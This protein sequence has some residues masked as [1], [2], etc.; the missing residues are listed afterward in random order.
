MEL[1]SIFIRFS[2]IFIF[3]FKLKDLRILIS[4][5][6]TS[7]N[8]DD[9]RTITNHSSGKMGISIANEAFAQGAQVTLSKGKTEVLPHKGIKIVEANNH[10]EMEQSVL[11]E[12]SRHD[13]F[14]SVAAVSDYKA[15]HVFQGKRT[16]RLVLVD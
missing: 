11:N 5:G 9:A 8:I 16:V 6:A 13:I 3:I 15:D 2:T 10:K 7:E 12:A 1:K 4:A 14:I